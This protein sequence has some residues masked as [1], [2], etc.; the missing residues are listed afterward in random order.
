MSDRYK[1]IVRRH[2][3]GLLGKAPESLDPDQVF[4]LLEI[5]PEDTNDLVGKMA[6]E[7]NIT[8]PE[9]SDCLLEATW[10]EGVSPVTWGSLCWLSA[11][12]E[13]AKASFIRRTNPAHDFTI[14]SLAACLREGR[15]ID[16]GLR[17]PVEEAL[18][19]RIG[20]LLMPAVLSVAG[21][22]IHLTSGDCTKRCDDTQSAVGAGMPWPLIGFIA[23]LTL[24]WLLWR[25]IPGLIAIRADARRRDP[26]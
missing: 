8:L 19:G 15:Y 14:T 1:E 4:S 22:A 16:S 2:I 12:S 9:G 13:A 10:Q 24:C 18:P 7:L 26:G 6:E 23:A 20:A 25:T 5:D 21:I 17:V 3:A 11:F